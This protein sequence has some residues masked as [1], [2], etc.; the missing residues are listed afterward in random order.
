MISAYAV[1][2]ALPYFLAAW[3]L[4]GPL[5]RSARADVIYTYTGNA[6]DILPTGLSC[7]PVC[8]VTGSFTLAQPLAANLSLATITPVSFSLTSAGV[9]LTDGIPSDKELRITTNTLGQIVH[10]DWEVVG[11]ANGPTARISTENYVVTVDD[12]YLGIGPPPFYFGT[13]VGLVFPPGTWSVA[14]TVP[15]PGSF[16]LLGTGLLG[17]LRAAQSRRRI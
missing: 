13:L 2:F 1:R 11:P 8:N 12:V 7:P 5:A 4:T 14:T 6:F 10:W 17:V 9:T 15:E 16:L 3:F